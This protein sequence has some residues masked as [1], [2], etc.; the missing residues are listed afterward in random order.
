[1]QRNSAF[2]F[3]NEV[4]RGLGSLGLGIVLAGVCTTAWVPISMAERLEANSNQIAGGSLANGV[5]TIDLEVREGE[6]FPEDEHGPSLKVFALAER[7]KPGRVPGPLIRVCEGTTIHVGIHNLLSVAVVMHGMH[8]RPGK[9]DDVLEIPSGA[10]R[11]ATFQA[12]EPGAYYY[13]ASA[14]GDTLNGRPYREDSQLNGAFIVDPAGNVPAD[15]IFVISVW[16]DR[17]KPEESFDIPVINGKSWP[18]TERLEYVAGTAVR[19]RWLNASAGVHPMHMHGS[20]FRVDAMGDAERDTV[21]PV[22]PPQAGGHTL[23]S[24]GWDHDH[25]LAPRG[26]GSLALSLP[27]FDPYLTRYNDAPPKRECRTPQHGA[28]RSR[29]RYGRTGHG[30]HRFASARRPSASETAKTTAEARPRDCKPTRRRES[31]RLRN[32]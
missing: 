28:R 9:E 2:A 13:W 12:G 32:Q 1:M 5:L 11:E 3:V 6:W 27:H 15:R 29:T 10:T 25:I 7:G 16:R 22:L 8:S 31:Q 14:G 20:Y 21:L 19:W 18:Y 23:D 4:C 17:Q 24:R 26:A 30:N